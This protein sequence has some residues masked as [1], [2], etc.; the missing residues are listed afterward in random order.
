ML[1]NGNFGTMGY[2]LPAALGTAVAENEPICC[3]T[4]DGA[5]LQAVRDVETAIRLNLPVCVVVLNDESYGVIRHRQE[6]E[7]GLETTAS[8]DSPDL[9][10][11]A[12][13]LG[14][15]AVTVRSLEALAVVDDFLADPNGP[16]VLDVRTIREVTRLGFPPY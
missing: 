3:Y 16:L 5:F 9:G 10:A 12:R 14:A 15:E 2:A 6:M 7:Y 13:G 11:T 8:Y 1:V 4:G